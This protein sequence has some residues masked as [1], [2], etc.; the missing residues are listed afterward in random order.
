MVMKD[1]RLI[2]PSDVRLLHFGSKDVLNNNEEKEWRAGKLQRAMKISNCEHVPI[3][4]YMQLP[5]GEK[6]ETESD[7]IDYADDYVIV[8]GGHYIPV[9]AIL[10]VGV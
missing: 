1:A 4:L 7:L 8:K 9:S 5:N 6:L 2:N 3:S 10:D